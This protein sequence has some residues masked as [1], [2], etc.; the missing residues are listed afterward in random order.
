MAPA[1]VLTLI[2]LASVLACCERFA[3]GH[4]CPAE[5]IASVVPRAFYVSLT[6][7]FQ[8]GGKCCAVRYCRSAFLTGQDLPVK[9]KILPGAGNFCRVLNQTKGEIIL[10]SAEKRMERRG[11]AP[12]APPH[13]SQGFPSLQVT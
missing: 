2:I 8:R 5:A 9:G 7:D 6:L 13:I 12:A 3:Q 4:S 1:L 10:K 11:N